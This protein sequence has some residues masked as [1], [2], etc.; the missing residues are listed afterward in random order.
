MLVNLEK[1]LRYAHGGVRVVTY[2]PGLVDVP[3]DAAIHALDEG[4]GRKPTKAQQDKAKQAATAEQNPTG[5]PG[6]D[7][8]TTDQAKEADTTGGP[9]AV[10]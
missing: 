2:G 8:E 10:D 7:N 6:S 3:N 5:N 4:Y 1:T 9:K